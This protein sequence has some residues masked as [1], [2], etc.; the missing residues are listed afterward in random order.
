MFI[1]KIQFIHLYF[2]YVIGLWNI[3][4]NALI[5]FYES[6]YILIFIL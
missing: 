1:Q 6:L 4:F 5:I 2:N 3:Q